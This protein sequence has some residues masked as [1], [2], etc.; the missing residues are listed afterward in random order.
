MPIRGVVKVSLLHVVDR[1]AR[2]VFVR[3]QRILRCPVA[4]SD[5]LLH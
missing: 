2:A 5:N 4:L 1:V 3:V